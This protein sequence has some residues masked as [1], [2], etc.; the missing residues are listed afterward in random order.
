MVFKEKAQKCSHGSNGCYSIALLLV[1]ILLPG[2]SWILSRSIESRIV[3]TLIEG[4]LRIL[5]FVSYIYL[6]S[7]MEDIQRLFM[8][9]GAE[10]KAINCIENGY[11]LT[12]EN[13]K[14]QSRNISVVE[15]VYFSCY[16]YK[17]NILYVY[18]CGFSLA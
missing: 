2:L 5:I 4:A 10:H 16:V 13:V 11:E 17:Y 12:V 7:K 9:H 8:Y 15:Q 1:F 3:M 14:T 18:S 6:I